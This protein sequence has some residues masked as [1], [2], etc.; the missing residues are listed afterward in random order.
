MAK[1]KRQRDNSRYGA[2]TGPLCERSYEVN[3]TRIGTLVSVSMAD[4]ARL[5]LT[6]DWNPSAFISGRSYKSPRGKYAFLCESDAEVFRTVYEGATGVKMKTHP[7]GNDYPVHVDR[8]IPFDQPVGERA[9]PGLP[10]AIPYSCSRDRAD[11]TDVAAYNPILQSVTDFIMYVVLCDIVDNHAVQGPK[12]LETTYLMLRQWIRSKTPALSGTFYDDKTRMMWVYQFRTGFPVCPT[13]HREFGRLRNIHL[14]KTY[15]AYQP[16]CSSRCAYGDPYTASRR[17][18]SSM[19]R[20]GVPHPSKSAEIKEAKRQTLLRKYGTTG[21]M[22][23]KEIR[24]K[25]IATNRKRYGTDYPAQNPSI[26]DKV[27]DTIRKRYGVTNSLLIPGMRERIRK[28][29]IERYGVESPLQNESLHKKMV[30]TTRERYGF[31][32]PTQDPDKMD[33]IISMRIRNQKLENR[34]KEDGLVFDSGWELRF[35]QYCKRRGFDVIYHPCCLTYEFNGREFRYYPDFEV[36]GKLYEIKGDC[37]INRDGTWRVP[38]RRK[39][40]SDE[41]YRRSCDRMEAK[42]QC[43]VAHGVIVVS[44]EEM[45]D[46]GGVFNV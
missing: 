9:V 19:A 14:S 16:H 5:G 43:I 31:D 6:P 40:M 39:G 38:F 2:E 8:F 7:K 24:G 1:H 35:Y 33:M 45:K 22:R 30:Q 20:Y 25:A 42:R 37:F 12:M 28:T 41:E 17:E 32:Y 4:L 36:N 29:M 34:H 21:I 13:C 10:D 3:E 46:L 23:I 18:A 26:L 27:H 11:C 44:R 15:V